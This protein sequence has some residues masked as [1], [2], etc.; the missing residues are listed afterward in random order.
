MQIFIFCGVCRL[1]QN[2]QPE[3]EVLAQQ[4]DVS[5]EEEVPIVLLIYTTYT[6]ITEYMYDSCSAC[7]ALLWRLHGATIMQDETEYE[8]DSE[9]EGYGLQVLKP[10]FI[11][12]AERDV[13]PHHWFNIFIQ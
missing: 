7:P 12:K 2:K 8:T 10:Q 6:L 5:D 11:R 9:D 13:S 1:K 4:E 3:E